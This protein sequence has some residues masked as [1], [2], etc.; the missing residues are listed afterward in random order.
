MNSKDYL[1]ARLQNL[2]NL[3][4]TYFAVVITLTGGI[5]SLFRDI[6]IIN[7]ILIPIGVLIDFFFLTQI[8]NITKQINKV[9]KMIKEI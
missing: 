4:S 9:L 1:N 3:R 5:V 2:M 8:F 6:T 7:L